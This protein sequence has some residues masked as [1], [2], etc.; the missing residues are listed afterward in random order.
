M[1]EEILATVEASRG[2]RFFGITTLSGL[3][4]LLISIALFRPPAELGWQVFLV[5]MAAA[6]AWLADRMRR[7]TQSR[8][9]LT[10]TE[11]RTSDGMVIA[12]I[13]EIQSLDRGMLAF[14][15]SNG[16]LMK[17]RASDRAVWVPGLW[18]RVG[19]RVGVGGMTAASQTKFMAEIISAMMAEREAGR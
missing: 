1:N 15:P 13:D 18:W 19:R 7:A 14:K 9:E 10:Q 2:R 11:V 6:A 12:K 5:A 17:L 16:F 4:V 8:I 3:A